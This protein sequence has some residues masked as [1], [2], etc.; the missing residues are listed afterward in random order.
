MSFLTEWITNIILFVLLATVVDMLLPS[1]VMKKYTKI[2]VGLLLITI[3]LTPLFQFLASD[4]EEVIAKVQF[5]NGND[6]EKV[7][8]LIE[9]KKKEIQASQDAYILEQMAVQMKEEAQ[10]VLG[11]EQNWV[12]T[13]IELQVHDLSTIPD[14]LSTISVFLSENNTNDEIAPVQPVSINTTT[15]LKKAT[16]KWKELSQELA[17]IWEVETEK[18]SIYEER[19][20]EPDNEP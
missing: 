12:I 13:N 9:M 4:F 15:P 1:S 11:D 18:I 2:V 7:E 3:I 14:G 8:N 5:Q 19:R 6:E 20:A 16:E 17:Q 10:R